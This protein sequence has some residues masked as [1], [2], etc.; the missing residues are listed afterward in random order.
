MKS[1]T[2]VADDR[3]G[4]LADISYILS[5]SNVNIEALSV[6]VVGKKAVIAF[7]VKDPLRASEVLSK[8][9]FRIAE[10]NSIVIKL[11]NKPD[12]ITKIADRLSDQDVHIENVNILTS[13]N[14]G[15]VFAINVDKPRKAVKLLNDFLISPESNNFIY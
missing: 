9:G 13:D 3:I 12:E 8:N 1:I 7:I 11:P 10:M 5:K 14:N 4:L 6:D 15:G 2:V